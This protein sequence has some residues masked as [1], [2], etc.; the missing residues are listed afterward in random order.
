VKKSSKSSQQ[1]PERLSLTLSTPW[2]RTVVIHIKDGAPAAFPDEVTIRGGGELRFE[3]AGGPGFTLDFE[4][5]PVESGKRS[6]ES[7]P[8][9]GLRR[10]NMTVVAPAEKTHFKYSITI[11]G[12]T[13]DPE[14]IIEPT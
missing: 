4:R 5:S 14:I 13:T 12:V 8:G 1:S 7:R 9:Y 11:D 3:M 6:F 2:R 10:C